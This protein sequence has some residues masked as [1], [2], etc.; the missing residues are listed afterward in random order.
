MK[1]GELLARIDD[2]DA[3][4]N[5][6]GWKLLPIPAALRA[7]VELHKPQ[8]ITLPDGSWGMNC[9]ECDGW[10]YPCLTIQTIKLGIAK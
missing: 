9:D 3:T 7:V 8:K 4:N 1:Y 2:S 6:T 10:V 5:G